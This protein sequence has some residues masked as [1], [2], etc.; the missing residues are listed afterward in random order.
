MR[1]GPGTVTVLVQVAFVFVQSFSGALF[2]SFCVGTAAFLA[3]AMAP[4]IERASLRSAD[5]GEHPEAASRVGAFATPHLRAQGSRV[6]STTD[7]QRGAYV[8]PMPRQ[9]PSDPAPASDRSAPAAPVPTPAPPY[10]PTEIAQ[11]V[12][13]IATPR[14]GPLDTTT[15]SA[16]GGPRAPAAPRDPAEP[17]IFPAP[18]Q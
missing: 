6:A 8:P 17:A 13:G 18:R 9:A 4:G 2:L 11:P 12:R 1:D 10:G 14:P 7:D 16:L 15:R 3:V 5:G